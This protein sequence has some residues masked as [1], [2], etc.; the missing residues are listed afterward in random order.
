L[1]KFD[2]RLPRYDLDRNACSMADRG[3]VWLKL[4]SRGRGCKAIALSKLI[5]FAMLD[6]LIWPADAN[7]GHAETKLTQRFQDGRAEAA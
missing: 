6:E 7:N 3:K 5:D 1:I 2:L 4:D